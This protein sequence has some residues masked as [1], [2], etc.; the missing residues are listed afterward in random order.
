MQNITALFRSDAINYNQNEAPSVLNPGGGLSTKKKYLALAMP[1]I[2]FVTEAVDMGSISIVDVLYFSDGGTEDER[3]RRI[4]DYRRQSGFKILWTSDF[5]ILRWLPKHR[6]QILD[7]TDII[8]ANSV[9]M[10]E[11]LETYF[12]TNK[13]ALLTDTIDTNVPDGQINRENII[14]S[15]SNILLEKGIDDIISLYK[16]MRTGT[17]AERKMKK[18]FIGGSDSWGVEIREIDSFELE[19]ALEEVCDLQQMK[20]DDVLALGRK[21][22][23]YASFARFETFGYALVEAMLGGCWIFARPHLAYKDRIYAGVVISAD[24]ALEMRSE[25]QKFLGTGENKRNDTAIQFVHD[26][27]SLDVFRRQFRD[28]V[29]DLYAI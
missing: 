27:Y 26:N 28:I 19:L 14:Y 3:D 5:E 6:E 20:N 11:L 2:E 12:N 25:I 23:I 1:H 16:A 9:Y 18:M 17:P 15:C 4:K 13:V 29:G 10:K 22:L 8:A 24:S 7:A 21:A